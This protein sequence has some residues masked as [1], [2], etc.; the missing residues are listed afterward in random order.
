LFLAKNPPGLTG[1]TTGLQ[2]AARGST[3]M[4]GSGPM[5]AGGARLNSLYG[6]GFF[7]T[8]IGLCPLDKILI[9]FYG[10]IVH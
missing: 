4:P 5:A 9:S 1:E 8:L 10:Q 6:S 2:K 7:V 3:V